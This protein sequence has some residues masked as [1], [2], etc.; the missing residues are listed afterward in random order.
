MLISWLEKFVYFTKMIV[1]HDV[2]RMRSGEAAISSAD[3]CCYEDE[4]KENDEWERGKVIKRIKI[5]YYFGS[6][7]V[8][9]KDFRGSSLKNIILI[10]GDQ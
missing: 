2:G 4:W 3:I 6:G 1:I 8:D 10:N 7:W 9:Y 5:F